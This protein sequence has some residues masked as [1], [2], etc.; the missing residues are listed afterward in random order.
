VKDEFDE[1]VRIEAEIRRR[2]KEDYTDKALE[3]AYNP[4]NVG[5]IEDAD[6]FGRVT[7]SCGD[8]M[9]IYMRVIDGVIEDCKFM[10]DG[11][12][13]TIACGSV[14]TEML[15]GKTLEEAARIKAEDILSVLGGLP[16]ENLH[17]PF[18]AVSTLNAALENFRKQREAES[19]R[20]LR[21]EQEGMW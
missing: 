3:E 5:R 2:E 10:T 7:G 11:C 19:E 12:G 4:K 15:K 9:E 17:C 16:P 8:T 6:C 1:I 18:L 13:A 14:L 20:D 21:N